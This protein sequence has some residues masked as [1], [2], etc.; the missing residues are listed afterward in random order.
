MGSV[1]GQLSPVTLS[2]SSDADLAQKPIGS[3]LPGDL[4]YVASHDGQPE[5]PLYYLSLVSVADRK[6]VV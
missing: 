6:S 4:A 3:L 1:S 5:G 2:C